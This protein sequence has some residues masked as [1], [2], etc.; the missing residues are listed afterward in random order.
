M[1]L[2]LIQLWRPLVYPL[3]A[4]P[5]ILAVVLPLMSTET[6]SQATQLFRKNLLFEV[7]NSVY[8]KLH[9]DLIIYLFLGNSKLVKSNTSIMFCQV[10]YNFLHPIRTAVIYRISLNQD[11]AVE[12]VARRRKP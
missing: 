7:V 10:P 4:P 6:L 5:F 9:Y 12:S 3:A 8:I 11:C 2:P 1:L